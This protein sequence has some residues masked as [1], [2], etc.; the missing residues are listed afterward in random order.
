MTEDGDLIYS[1]PSNSRQALMVHSAEL[2]TEAAVR[3]AGA[4]ALKVGKFT[5]AGTH[6]RCATCSTLIN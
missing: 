5:F 6:R 4:K 1:I 2:R 3:A